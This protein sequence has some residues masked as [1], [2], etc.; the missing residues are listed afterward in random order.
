LE[1]DV[2]DYKYIDEEVVAA[3]KWEVMKEV[4]ELRPIS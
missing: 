1:N 3:F 2:E 4:F